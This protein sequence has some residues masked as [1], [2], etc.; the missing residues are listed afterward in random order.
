MNEFEEMV[1]TI[2]AI[3][4]ATLL[5]AV[6]LEMWR[7]YFIDKRKNVIVAR[8]ALDRH[9]R[10][11]RAVV[12]ADDVHDGIKHLL[13]QFSVAVSQRSVA[14]DIARRIIAKERPELS[15]QQQQILEELIG[16]M[17]SLIT[18][19]KVM[20]QAI[21][22]VIHFGFLSMIMRWP[23]TE[24]ALVRLAVNDAAMVNTHDSI[25]QRVE[26]VLEKMPARPSGGASLPTWRTAAAAAI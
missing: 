19:D 15:V 7:A 8:E 4:L 6:L 20:A 21:A 3:I 18:H 10:A 17:R 14:N 24:P 9:F 5:A 13:V 26:W 23:E 1:L 2:I 25:R 12:S 22:M 11:L 16:E